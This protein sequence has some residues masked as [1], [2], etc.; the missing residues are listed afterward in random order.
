MKTAPQPGAPEVLAM[1]P[2]HPNAVGAP[3]VTQK[4]W[5]SREL[6]T[7]EGLSGLPESYADVRKPGSIMVGFWEEPAALGIPSP[8]RSIL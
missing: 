6:Q 1:R 8:E 3:M 2:F 7:K 5:K 4:V